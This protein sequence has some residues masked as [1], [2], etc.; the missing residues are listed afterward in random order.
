MGPPFIRGVQKGVLNYCL[1]RPCTAIAAF[2]LE[3]LGLYHPGS[4]DPRDANLYI[5]LA[6]SV[7]QARTQYSIHYASAYR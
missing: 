3:P 4:L 1:V 2:S 5:A 6:N 7:S